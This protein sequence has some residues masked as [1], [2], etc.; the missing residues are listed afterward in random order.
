MP[1]PRPTVLPVR[2]RPSD[3][4]TVRRQFRND[5]KSL[6][7]LMRKTTWSVRASER[8]SERANTWASSVRQLDAYLERSVRKRLTNTRLYMYS[9]SYVL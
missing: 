8:A 1:S 7:D 2:P 3:R 4:P 6:M 5:W 9:I